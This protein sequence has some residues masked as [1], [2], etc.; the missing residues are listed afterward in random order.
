M[1]QKSRWAHPGA[2]RSF[3]VFFSFLF[4]GP[5]AAHLSLS[6][7]PSLSLG[8]DAHADDG[9]ASAS[10]VSP[11]VLK[12]SQPLAK[13]TQIFDAVKDGH[14]VA[15]MT[16]AVI[17]LQI[18]EIPA[19]PSQ[20]RAKFQTSNGSPSVRIDGYAPVT[21]ATIWTVK[22]VP[23]AS[24]HVWI[25]DGQKVKLTKAQTSQLT[26]ELTIAGSQS[27]VA[28]GTAACESFALEKGTV[29]TFTVPGN[30]RGYQMKSSSLDLYD[31]ANGSVIFSL[32]MLEGTGQLFWSTE[33]KA[34]FVHLQTRGDITVD[35][36]AKWS[37]LNPLKK[38]EMM[39]QAIP[40]QTLITG[41]SLSLDK[42]PPLQKAAK[43]IPIRPRRDLKEKTIGVIETGA[44][45]YVTETIVGWANILPKH[46]GMTPPAD[47]GFW[48][49]SSNLSPSN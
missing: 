3:G 19:D 36:W 8:A 22:D 37:A 23:V 17:P 31:D 43:D 14:A 15:E 30:G 49:E 4:C 47:T 11:C 34:G 6:A 40:S 10:T 41:A 2:I 35:A 16:G 39:D 28:K 20:G 12:G 1:L 33:S 5:V 42:P 18:S 27:Q 38:G 21:A 45:F 24:G 32:N 29:T 26:A 44:E 25:S 13:G 46:L 7:G 9:T 48:I